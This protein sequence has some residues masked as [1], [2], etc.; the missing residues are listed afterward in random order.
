MKHDPIQVA[1]L[2]ARIANDPNPRLRYLVGT[3][4]HIQK[5]MKMLLP[6]KWYERILARELGLDKE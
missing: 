1:R 4:A 2:I 3:D 5:W 6:W